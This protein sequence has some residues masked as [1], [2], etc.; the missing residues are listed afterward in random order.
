MKP[1]ANRTVLKPMNPSYSSSAAVGPFKRVVVGLV[2]SSFVA[3]SFAQIPG[4]G[5]NPLQALQALQ[6]GGVNLG[7]GA[8]SAFGGLGGTSLQGP[9][10]INNVDNSLTTEQDLAGANQPTERPRPL[11]KPS[12][13]ERF[14]LS[15]T[16]KAIQPYGSALFVSR[17]SIG[18]PNPA[19]PGDYVLAPGDEVRVNVWGPITI[20]YKAVLGKSGEVSIPRIGTFNLAGVKLSELENHLRAEV[21]RYYTNFN[22]SAT[23]GKLRGIQVYV[24][25]Q[26]AA[27]GLYTVGALSSLVSAVFEVAEPGPEG[28]YRNIQLRRNN[29]VVVQFD[30][31]DFIARGDSSKDARLVAG[32]VI[33]I[34]PAG[35][36]VAVV[37][38]VDSPAIFELKPQGETLDSVLNLA[39][40]GRA[41]VDTRTVKLERINRGDANTPR[42]I[43][44]V[45]VAAMAATTLLADGDVVTVNAARPSFANAVTLRGNVAM[46]MRHAFKDGMRIS[47]L[48]PD[49]SALISLDY[50]RR[51]NALVQRYS[52]TEKAEDR[53][54]E[55]QLTEAALRSQAKI[56][57]ADKPALQEA[58]AR[59]AQNMATAPAVP[60]SKTDAPELAVQNRV[61]E[62][63]LNNDVRNMLD[64][65]NWD[66]AVV[67]RMDST[68]IRARLI[69][70]NLGKA[71]ANPGSVDNVG[72]Q[73]G[74]VVSIFSV[75]D[76]TVPKARKSAFVRLVGE[77]NN[78][79]VYQVEPGETLRDAVRKAGGFTRDA[80]VFG[81]ELRRESTRAD[82][83]KRYQ[84]ALNRIERD[85]QRAAAFGAAAALSAEDATAR[86]VQTEANARL[87]E[88]LRSVKPTGRVILTLGPDARNISDLPNIALEDGDSFVIPPRPL[89]VNVFG[90]VFGEGAFLHNPGDSVGS[91]IERAGGPVKAADAG[92]TFVIRPNGSVISAR[93]GLLSWVGNV[94]GR[95]AVPGDT[96]FV[97]E[98]YERI[99][100]LRLLRDVSLVFGQLGLGVAALRSI[101]RD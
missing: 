48:I 91:F 38:G 44:D 21:A 53:K 42:S 33:V 81:G 28:S 82:Q 46:P 68:E 15:A 50:Y 97:P 100:T 45:P 77:V 63:R 60:A 43:M 37:G 16:G 79:G 13:F 39:G 17:N 25:G 20:N 14:V 32:D 41:T 72:L 86:R 23:V 65:I 10:S 76:F 74:D 85:I 36:R 92:S 9:L 56:T 51:K 22:L 26:A 29:Q 87:L 7:A 55:A 8:A 96:I 90:A 71:L 95:N 30:L 35:A 88:R 70:F 40:F 27:P 49:R 2:L 61:T 5:A 80:Y 58:A 31:Y 34:N 67:E 62:E 66:Y 4:L 84:E 99:P 3:S 57:A 73:P 64:E 75:K 11:R 47:D 18:Q 24:V 12:E 6:G 78:P 59:G 54:Q 101:T 19:V 89:T 52:D 83:E 93:Q 69:P 94:G 98:D 1:A